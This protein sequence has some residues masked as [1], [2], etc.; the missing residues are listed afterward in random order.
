ML[1][2]LEAL[3]MFMPENVKWT[4]PDGGYTIWV[5]LSYSYGTENTFKK[6]LI[7]NG[8]LVSPGI[9]YFYGSKEQK[10]FRISISSLN[11]KEI[12]EGIKRLGNAL[13]QLIS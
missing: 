10:Y 11:E 8:V 12:P 4:K 2:A 13:R 1:I 5:S 7:N 3:E 9:Y 6:T